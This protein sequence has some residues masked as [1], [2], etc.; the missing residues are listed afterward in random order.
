MTRADDF[1]ISGVAYVEL[2]VGNAK[3]ACHF[4]RDM[5][6]VPV[7][8]RGLE[9]GERELAS[10]CLVSGSARMVVTS[11]LLPGTA[12]SEHVALHGD[13]V[14]DIGFLV[15]DATAA[16]ALALER[17]ARSAR[18]PQVFPSDTG[19]VTTAAIHAFGD[20]LHSFVSREGDMEVWQQGF[21][22]LQDKA[23]SGPPQVIEAI[24]HIAVAVQMGALEEQVAFY[25]DVMGF[26]AVDFA[27][28]S[29]VSGEYST[30]MS[31]VVEG[32]AGKVKIPIMEPAAGR[33][34]SQ[35]EEFL[36]Y[37]RSA[38][39]QHLAFST[40]D[41]VAAVE[42][43]RRNEIGFVQIAGRYYN[44]VADRVPEIKLLL[45][46]LERNSILADRD[47]DGHL[48]QTFTRHAQ[49]RPTLFFELIERNGARGFGSGN[50]KSLFEATERE[51]AARGNL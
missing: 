23:V 36:F 51:Q 31:K 7:A 13:G 15:A 4:Y 18:Q 45:H 3:Q 21:V 47:E 28:L 30:M 22:P 29:S 48:L 26:L 38:G 19:V 50:V 17:G 27:A 12:L 42:Q 41:I 24:D 8:Y 20:T 16:Y 14:Y 43:M 44:D 9:T 39:V 5:G 35:I 32:G 40:P 11:P 49:D 6:F 34:R 1:P 10:W 33:K 46:D 2:L 25:Q 37:Y